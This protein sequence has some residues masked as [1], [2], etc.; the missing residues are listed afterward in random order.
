MKKNYLSL[1]FVVIVF[2]IVCFNSCSSDETTFQG[3]RT[4]KTRQ[5]FISDLQRLVENQE[6]YTPLKKNRKKGRSFNGLVSDTSLSDTSQLRKDVQYILENYNIVQDLNEKELKGLSM[7]LDE[8][9]AD[10]ITVDEDAFHE[11]TAEYK[12]NAFLNAYRTINNMQ[13]PDQQIINRILSNDSIKM[14]E[15]LSLALVYSAKEKSLELIETGGI[16]KPLN[17]EKECFKMYNANIKIC[18][19]NYWIAAVVTSLVFSLEG[20]PIGV[21]AGIG[22]AAISYVDCTNNA[23][24]EY[25]KCLE[26]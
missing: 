18:L 26:K 5:E 6:S 4:Q 25:K 2:A 10:Y 13:Y 12:T 3:L 17:K 21:V 22:T 14:I 23:K 15:K 16:V 7:L 24:A 20:G 19:R 8:E 9:F 1:L 11:Y